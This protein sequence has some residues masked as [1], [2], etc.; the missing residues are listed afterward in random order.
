MT[1][2]ATLPKTPEAAKIDPIQYSYDELK[3]LSP[4]EY[5]RYWEEWHEGRE[6]QLSSEYG[7]LSLRSIDW[8]EDGS[9]VRIPNFPGAWTQSGDT[10]VYTPQP[11]KDVYNRGQVIRSPKVIK[12]SIHADV[13]VEDFDFE[14]VRAQLIKRIGPNRQFAVRQRDPQS[15]TRT[16]FAGVPHFEPNQDWIYP[17]RYEALSQWSTVETSAVLGDLSH[18]ETQIGTLFITIGGKEYGLVVFQG[19]NDD[20]G[21]TRVNPST[22]ETEYLDNRQN[23]EGSGFVLFRDETS[24]KQ[25][26]G[27][28]R[29][30]HVDLREPEKVSYV[31]FNQATNLPCAFTYYC[32]CPFAPREN[33][34]PFEVL[35]GERTPKIVDTG[36]FE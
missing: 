21:W 18:D 29:G 28:A 32:T 9:S 22:G 12:V 16:A 20:S 7:W 11:G 33:L 6:A 5:E 25:T 19:H 10:V 34:F 26:Y 13:N 27:G 14:G 1:T 31:D 35:A 24:G 4:Q 23:T 15:V 36:D 8:L 2:T 3:A 30:L 17:A